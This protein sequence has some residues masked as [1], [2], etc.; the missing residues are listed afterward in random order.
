M[1]QPPIRVMSIMAHQ[2]D[3]EFTTGGLFAWLRHRY[4]DRAVLKIIATT[5]GASGH[6]DLSLEQTFRR[7]EQ[8]AMASAD[9]IG[10]S[11]E[12]LSLLDNSH[13]VGQVFPDRNTLGGL[14]NAI[15][16]FQ[17]DF[18]VCPPVITDPRA[19]IHIDHYNTAWA[20]RFVA[21]QLTVPHAYPALSEKARTARFPAPLII[22]CD[23]LYACENGFDVALDISAVYAQKQRMALCHESQIFEWLPWNGMK[24]PPT[25]EQFLANFRNRHHSINL[26]YGHDDDAPREFFRVTFWGR[27]PTKEDLAAVFPDT[28]ISPAALATLKL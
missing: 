15:R 28:P 3:F 24:T 27:R 7:R 21:Y 11:Y 6:Q 10:A 4:G 19:G 12:C 8:E 13:A 20:V 2:D 23:D 25:P 9:V 22:N 17:P 1:S 14:W 5:R 18:I 16:D 26:R